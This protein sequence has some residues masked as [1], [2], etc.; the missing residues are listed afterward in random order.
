MQ[1]SEGVA[2]RVKS[3][4]YRCKETQDRHVGYDTSVDVTY[5]V[6]WWPQITVIL[7]GMTLLQEIDAHKEGWREV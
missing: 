4:V 1:G 2:E 5:Y 7:K 6:G 3:K